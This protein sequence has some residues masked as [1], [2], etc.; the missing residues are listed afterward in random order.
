MLLRPMRSI[1]SQRLR[2][3]CRFSDK[4]TSRKTWNIL[5]DN[6]IFTYEIAFITVLAVM[7]VAIQVQL[8]AHIGDRP[9]LADGVM[10]SDLSKIS[11]F[12]KKFWLNPRAPFY[13]ILLQ[14]LNNKIYFS[15]KLLYAFSSIA[16]I[17][18]IFRN[19][20]QFIWYNI[21]NVDFF[22]RELRT[23]CDVEQFRYD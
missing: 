18:R 12:H 11:I 22:H 16:L 6:G 14:V 21:S 9:P 7:V 5:T 13:P 19:S 20:P 17:Y 15:Q 4:D 8:A 23:L 1:L 2:K 10:Y 3:T